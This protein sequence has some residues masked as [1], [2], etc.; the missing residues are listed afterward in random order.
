MCCTLLFI[1]LL[2]LPLLL[3]PVRVRL[4]IVDAAC[5]AADIEQIVYHG[6]VRLFERL[7]KL[8]LMLFTPP[9]SPSLF[10]PLPLSTLRM[11]STPAATGEKAHGRR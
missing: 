4:L 5:L 9:L 10:L 2:F 1:S 3:L 8:Y 11:V 6:K 7:D